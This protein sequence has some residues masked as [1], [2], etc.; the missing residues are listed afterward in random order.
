M[1]SARAHTTLRLLAILVI[2]LAALAPRGGTG[3]RG[4]AV[5]KSTVSGQAQQST[6]R[7]QTHATSLSPTLAR[8]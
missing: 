5:A 2:A 7:G 1:L 8:R 6:A 4:A 3:G